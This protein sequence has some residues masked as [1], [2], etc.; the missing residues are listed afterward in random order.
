MERIE[1]PYEF[2][3]KY[4]F[5]TILLLSPFIPQDPAYNDLEQ[6][7]AEWRPINTSHVLLRPQMGFL[8]PSETEPPQ[9]GDYL[10]GSLFYS[11]TDAQKEFFRPLAFTHYSLID[12]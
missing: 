2:Q 10:P 4:K 7:W 6:P 12:S 3:D 9:P 11:L 1:K 5:P 8:A